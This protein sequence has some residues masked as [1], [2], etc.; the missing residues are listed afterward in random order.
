MTKKTSNTL[1]ALVLVLRDETDNKLDRLAL[2]GMISWESLPNEASCR[3]SPCSDVT[4]HFHAA[5]LPFPSFH[6]TTL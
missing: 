2:G 4:P 3:K 6:D 1:M 5:A